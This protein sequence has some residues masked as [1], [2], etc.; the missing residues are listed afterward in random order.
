MNWERG[1]F[2][3]NP[4][5]D[6]HARWFLTSLDLIDCFTHQRVGEN[7]EAYG[8]NTNFCHYVRVQLWGALIVFAQALL[9]ALVVHTLV[10]TPINLFGTSFF[11]HSLIFT[12][13]IGA[14]GFGIALT[15]SIWRPALG[16]VGDR[17]ERGMDRIA[18]GTRNQ[19]NKVGR[20]SIWK[21]IGGF[22][23]LG[24]KYIVMAKHKICPLTTIDRGD[25]LG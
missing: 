9:A 5:R 6:A 2:T 23:S 16:T 11:V 12:G 20:L 7:R 17:F 24:W 1:E 13:I 10:L 3:F 18:D 21:A 22:F 19:C 4:E 14:L 15:Y 25:N 8:T